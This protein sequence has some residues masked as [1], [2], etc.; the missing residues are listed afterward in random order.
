MTEALDL[1]DAPDLLAMRP[2]LLSVLTGA[3]DWK[4]CARL[5]GMNPVLRAE[6]E[7]IAPLLDVALDPMEE[8]ALQDALLAAG[9]LW[10]L[11]ASV[12]TPEVF[13]PYTVTLEGISAYC[14]DEGFRLWRDCALYPKNPGRHLVF[15][16]PDELRQ[17]AERRRTEVA[18]M[19]FRAR[20][21]LEEFGKRAPAKSEED[22]AAVRAMLADFRSR[23]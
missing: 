9:R 12:L 4:S 15:P 14:L 21:A 10:D 22:K 20:K 5:I 6:C 3:T 17:L 1:G 16:K 7:R 2:G 19:R 13:A 11:P 18:G 23:A 8:N